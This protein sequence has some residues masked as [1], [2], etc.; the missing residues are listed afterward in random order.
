MLL[1][2]YQSSH[3]S[4]LTASLTKFNRVLDC[5]DTGTGKTYTSAALS[6]SLSLKPFVV[7][8]K[9]VLKTWRTV[10]EIFGVEPVEII[11]YEKFVKRKNNDN[12]IDIDD[13]SNTLFI[14]DEAHRCK[15]KNTACNKLLK[16]IA[17]NDNSKILLLSATIADTP[18]NFYTFGYVL[19]LYPKEKY[20]KKWIKE[21]FEDDV[22][23][24]HTALFGSKKALRMEKSNSI[25]TS[26]ANII[27]TNCYKMK[28]KDEIK[29]QYDKITE[30][31]EKIKDTDDTL[32]L[33]MYCRMLIESYKIPTIVEIAS[34]KLKEGF[35]VVIFVNFSDTLK[36]LSV[37]LDCNCLIH[38][39]QTLAE[40]DENIAAFNSNSER[41][42]IAN[43]KSGSAGISLHD[44]V[45]GFKRVSIISPSWSAQ[46][47][48][49]VLGRIYRAGIKSD[50]LQILLY[51]EGT[52]E[53]KIAA[54]MNKKMEYIRVLNT[55]K[56]DC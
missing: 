27:T 8:P 18:E 7:C 13:T 4:N 5:S 43:I 37:V 47:I 2:D 29:S 26:F 23:S 9:S 14:F 22:K 50:A 33:I 35:S 25:T 36:T 52:I 34:S 21:I 38:G 30:L 10:L 6:K 24:L 44:T 3:L 55:G 45:G 42:L 20:A 56:K 51:C 40:R 16:K 1:F 28:N 46:D 12:D 54:K 31:T 49:Q 41:I 19:K 53:E 15:S 11:N 32:S 48:I 39:E 17:S